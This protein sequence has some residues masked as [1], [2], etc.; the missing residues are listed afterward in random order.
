MIRIKVHFYANGFRELDIDMEDWTE[1]R[2]E[3]ERRKIVSE[4]IADYM[5]KHHVVWDRKNNNF[6]YGDHLGIRIITAKRIKTHE[7]ENN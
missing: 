4:I 3:P 5:K 6:H 2:P 1:K 7:K